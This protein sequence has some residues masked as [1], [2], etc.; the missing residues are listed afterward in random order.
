[1]NTPITS[2]ILW[3]EASIPVILML[4]MLSISPWSAHS[5]YLSSA[6]MHIV[7]EFS[8]MLLALLCA[9][10]LISRFW[11]LGNRL[12]LL[13][14]MAFLVNALSDGLH[15]LLA[16]LIAIDWLLWPAIENNL[17]A[18]IQ[19]TSIVGRFLTGFFLL[20]APWLDAHMGLSQAPW[21]ETLR[22]AFWFILLTLVA[23]SLALVLPFEQYVYINSWLPRPIDLLVGI[24][25][26]GVFW[27]FMHTYRCN[28]DSLLWWVGLS[29]AMQVASQCLMAFSKEI[30]DINFTLSHIYRL[31][32][33]VVPLFGFSLYQ[34]R[35]LV[36]R[37]HAEQALWKKEQELLNLNTQLESLVTRR[38]EELVAEVTRHATARECLHDK[39]ERLRLALEV[40]DIGTWHWDAECHQE[41]RDANLNRILGEPPQESTQDYTDFLHRIHPEDRDKVKKQRQIAINLQANYFQE[42]RLIRNDG[43]VL[44]VRNCGRCFYNEEGHPSH[45]IGA[46][47]DIT[48][49]KQAEQ[50]LQQHQQS[51]KVEVSQRTTELRQMHEKFRQLFFN[52]KAV[53]LIIDPNNANIV[54]AN[55]AAEKYYGYSIK[56]LKS[57]KISDINTLTPKEISAE[58]LQAKTE[59]RTHF[60]F[61]HR[62]A[63]G[64]IRDVEVHSGPILLGDSHVLY[65]IIHDI[66]ERKHAEEQLRRSEARFRLLAEYATDM[67]SRHNAAGDYTYVSPS[68]YSLLGYRD[69]ELLGHS[70]YEF[71]HPDDLPTI[72]GLHQTQLGHSE[73]KA[74]SIS[75]RIR[76][77]DGR[78][79]WFETTT[80]TVHDE[81]S[82]D[83]KE[84]IAI[85]RDISERKQQELLLQQAKDE[86]EAANRAKSAF[87]ANMS[88]E[89]RTPLNGIL[90][91]AQ[92]LVH[93]DLSDSQREGIEVIRRSGDYLL[94]LINDI[95]DLSKIE[96]ERLELQT[97]TFN[98]PNFIHDNVEVFN[99]RAQQKNIIL[100]T[101]I[102]PNT[103]KWVRGDERRL[104]QI[105]FNL[106]SNAIKFTPKN[107]RV[108]IQVAKAL[109]LVLF[110][111]Q[112]TGIGIA[113]N[114]LMH[115][116]QPFEQ[117]EHTQHHAE[118]TGLGLSI[119]AKLIELMQGH[120][121]VDSQLDEG[122]E[123]RV[124]LPL[125][126]EPRETT[127]SPIQS[128]HRTILGY[129]GKR[130]HILIIDDTWENRLFLRQLLENIG[131]SIT[132]VDSGKAGVASVQQLLPDLVL[133]DLVMP[134][135]D[136]LETTRRLQQQQGLEHVPIIAVSASAFE[137][138]REQSLAAGCAAFLSKPLN[139][140]QLFATIA[141][142]LHL[143]W[144]YQDTDKVDE[145]DAESP[146][147]P[148]K[149][150]NVAQAK[151]LQELALRG[152][153]QGI[154]EYVQKLTQ[155]E[156]TLE[157]F[158]QYVKRL[159]DA[160]DEE[161]LCNM[162]EYYLTHATHD[163]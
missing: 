68:C 122:S 111:V 3:R 48:Q 133:V 109:G 55:L 97:S 107:G 82:G 154:I 135:I 27:L 128:E 11:V 151:V 143:T 139:T 148:S 22:T 18:F 99:T 117:I 75:Y 41:I 35:N 4:V 46:L 155:A 16:L 106:L 34:S 60:F 5:S 76:C 100:N 86:A 29:V 30:H 105:L 53:E 21:H 123:F 88:H 138:H 161:Q 54:D 92:V 2:F 42:H 126:E 33:Y 152:N 79:I 136:G 72:T 90:G 156:P 77:K 98:L 65:S 57:M 137:H 61:R 124:Y 130:K 132:D 101:F 47:F 129:E 158:A 50:Q 44:W 31:L 28:A 118:G 84:I 91:Y 141:Q 70:A 12:H 69:D 85:S 120:I 119:T 94:T 102:E 115:I 127:T 39:E 36:E 162:A 64:E 134:D 49:R 125:F 10:A 66:T 87:L 24:L 104:R 78:Y 96:A 52:N 26:L 150:P 43:E 9:F 113:K 23:S 80:R 95:L 63:S 67:I 147:W 15:G 6:G 157:D 159:A 121:E 160:L 73:Q 146:H 74:D 163:A 62:L 103:P 131:F 19:G 153:I 14:G 81:T 17:D 145:T 149:G 93:D 71:F 116:F 59:Q 110:K 58:M 51:L 38:T 114:K 144:I 89:L 1:M 37:L 20:C 25:L 40:A 142:H 83:I 45:M 32:A 7:L 140:Q 13:I 112:D 108:N 8:C 56:Q